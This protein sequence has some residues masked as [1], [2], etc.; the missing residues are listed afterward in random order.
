MLAPAEAGNEDMDDG[1]DEDE[2]DDGKD[3][4]DDKDPE[5]SVPADDKPDAE[6]AIIRSSG[7]NV[8]LSI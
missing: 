5:G 1:E 6:G 4:K 7:S 2:E 3:G 8:K